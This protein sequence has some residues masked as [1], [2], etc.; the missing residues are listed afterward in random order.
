MLRIE[1]LLLRGDG[2]VTQGRMLEETSLVQRQ[3]PAENGGGSG[4]GSSAGGGGGSVGSGPAANSA[5]PN[6]GHHEPGL[7]ALGAAAFFFVLDSP[8]LGNSHTEH[9]VYRY[10]LYGCMLVY[11]SFHPPEIIYRRDPCDQTPRTHFASLG[12]KNLSQGAWN[13][14]SHRW[15]WRRAAAV[16]G[17][18][19]RGRRPRSPPVATPAR[20]AGAAGAAE[21]AA[22]VAVAARARLQV[23]AEVGR[24]CSR[25]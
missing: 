3:G 5:A 13:A 8:R 25:A 16:A 4:S 6:G 11:A 12:H 21:A 24:T 23:Q 20:G 10:L 19:T 17:R 15:T 9:M 7:G 2:Q 22:A 1:N 18:T 14:S